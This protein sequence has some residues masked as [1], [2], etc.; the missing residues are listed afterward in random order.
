[1]ADHLQ[2]ADIDKTMDSVISEQ[3]SK[4]K[5]DAE[6]LRHLGGVLGVGGNQL[7]RGE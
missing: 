1:M 4:G 6:I 3:I 5:S 2:D 7:T